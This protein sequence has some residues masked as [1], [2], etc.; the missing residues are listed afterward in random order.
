MPA[1]LTQLADPHNHT[2]L[3]AAFLALDA[4][5]AAALGREPRLVG[6]TA[7]ATALVAVLDPLRHACVTSAMP[8]VTSRCASPAL[9]FRLVGRRLTLSHVG[10]SRAL[11]LRGRPPGAVPLTQDHVPTLPAERARIAACGGHVW[12]GGTPR[13]NGILAVSR[14]FCALPLRGSGVTAEPDLSTVTLRGDDGALLLATD[15]A[16]EQLSMRGAAAAL[17]RGGPEPA[18][19]ADALVDEALS[20]GAKDNISGVLVPLP[21]WVAAVAA[22]SEA[23]GAPQSFASP[24]PRRGLF[25]ESEACGNREDGRTRGDLRANAWIAG[26]RH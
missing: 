18:A 26:G 23:E 2:Q 14:A 17:L 7:G 4:D 11:L 8:R 22:A 24:R 10:D 9:R 1:A 12:L 5:V 3:R 25:D 13:V 19:A 20:R 6:A 16:F 15:G 21:G